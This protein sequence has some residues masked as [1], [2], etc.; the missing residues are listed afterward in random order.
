MEGSKALRNYELVFIAQ[1]DLD[2]EAMNALVDRVQQV[3]VNNGGEVTEVEQVGLRKLAYPIAKRKEGFYV[4]MHVNL[5][6]PAITELERTM[7]LSE[8]ILRHLL[9]RVDEVA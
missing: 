8:E 2:E 3:M 1:P 7:K 9:V 5:G 4:L 6:S